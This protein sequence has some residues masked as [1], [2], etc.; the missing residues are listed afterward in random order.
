[1]FPKQTCLHQSY[2]AV[3]YQ[4]SYLG[5]F[6]SLGFLQC[7]SSLQNLYLFCRFLYPKKIL[8]QISYIPDSIF[9]YICSTQVHAMNIIISRLNSICRVGIVVIKN[10]GLLFRANLIQNFV[11]KT[12]LEHCNVNFMQSF[13]KLFYKHSVINVQTLSRYAYTQLTYLVT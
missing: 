1:M 8:Y 11:S 6:W 5:F 9:I 7:F 4:Y 13:I 12:C 10:L 3:C 2:L